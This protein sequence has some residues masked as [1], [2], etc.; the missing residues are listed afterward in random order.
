LELKGGSRRVSIWVEM[1]RL[2]SGMADGGVADAA[3]QW[4]EEMD[5]LCCE[6]IGRSQG[7]NIRQIK[8]VHMLR[9]D[10]Y[11]CKHNHNSVYLHHARSLGL[12]QCRDVYTCLPN[13]VLQENRNA[14][15]CNTIPHGFRAASTNSTS[16]ASTSNMVNPQSPSSNNSPSPCPPESLVLVLDSL[17]HRQCSLVLDASAPSSSP[18]PPRW[19]AR[20]PDS[21]PCRI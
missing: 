9:R 19:V 1:G 11:Q 21:C 12:Y 16:S 17:A 14:M 13:P 3:M 8:E 5:G 20:R 4:R 10:I 6:S 7:F 15:Q 18:C 2:Q